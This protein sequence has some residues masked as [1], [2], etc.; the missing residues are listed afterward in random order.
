M[1]RPAM[2]VKQTIVRLP[3]GIAERI[4]VLVGNYRRAKFIRETIVKKV[5]ELE[6]RQ[7]KAADNG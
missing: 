5:E 6:R 7:A 4:D 2:Q 1:G 3:E